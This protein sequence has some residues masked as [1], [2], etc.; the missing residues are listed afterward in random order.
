M[1]A[2]LLANR[3]PRRSPGR[4]G[5]DGNCVSLPPGGQRHR[6]E[7]ASAA[8]PT[9]YEDTKTISISFL[10]MTWER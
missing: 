10:N 4:S 7:P 2:L 6:A 3:A 1:F 9:E 8:C 5:R